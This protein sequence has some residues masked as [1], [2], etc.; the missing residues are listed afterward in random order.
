MV[1]WQDQ[2]PLYV[3]LEIECHIAEINMLEGID[4]RR[5]I[6]LLPLVHTQ[7]EIMSCSS[8]YGPISANKEADGISQSTGLLIG[9]AG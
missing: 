4:I 3:L 7:P 9:A 6:C 8:Y 1:V 2:K 5:N